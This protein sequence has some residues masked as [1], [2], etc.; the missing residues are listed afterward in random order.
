M[1]QKTYN[2]TRE[3]EL[4]GRK[5][6]SLRSLRNGQCIMPAGSTFTIER[7]QGG[8]HLVSDPCPHCGIRVFISKVAPQDVNFTDQQNLWPKQEV[9]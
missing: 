7:K 8:F 5:V 4:I 3:S 1:D 6:I 2:N 9:E